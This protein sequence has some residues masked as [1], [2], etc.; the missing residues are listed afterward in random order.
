MR[1]G[2][3]V[4]AVALVAGI[5]SVAGG[6]TAPDSCGKWK[7]A[8]APYDSTMDRILDHKEVGFT[9][10]QFALALDQY[11]ADSSTAPLAAIERRA[12]KI[13][14]AT[15]KVSPPADL[16]TLHAKLDA[17]H[18]SVAVA[19]RAARSED[20][21]SSEQLLAGCLRNLIAYYERMLADLTAQGC[22]SGDAE[23]LEKKTLPG[24]RAELKQLE[25]GRR[26]LGTETAREQERPTTPPTVRTIR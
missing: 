3:I 16:K 12:D 25:A 4:A 7:A 22:R 23:A 20:V 24:M 9:L 10:N 13:L 14:R 2:G 8:I 11:A 19:A 1:V 18:A 17:F 5:A 26:K 15:R 6:D 21:A